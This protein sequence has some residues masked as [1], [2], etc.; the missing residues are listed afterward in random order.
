MK[1]KSLH[2]LSLQF[3][4]TKNSLFVQVVAHEL[5][6]LFPLLGIVTLYIVDKMG[7]CTE[8]KLRHLSPSI[9]SPTLILIINTELRYSKCRRVI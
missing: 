8:R 6:Y 4:L 7:S 1:N 5:C 3:L 9:S 2:Y